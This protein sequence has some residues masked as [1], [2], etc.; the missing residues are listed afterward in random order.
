VVGMERGAG[1]LRDWG[2]GSENSRD[3]YF[4]GTRN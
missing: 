4:L 3:N 1:V 2:E